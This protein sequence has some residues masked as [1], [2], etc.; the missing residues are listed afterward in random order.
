MPSPSPPDP[1]TGA[2][3]DPDALLSPSVLRGEAD[4]A[5]AYEL[6]FL[7]D[8]ATARRVEAWAA[9][10]LRRDP[11]GAA[12]ADGAYPT[13]TL[14]LDTP[15]LDVLHRAPGLAGRKY[16]VRKYDDGG[17]LY[18]ER[19]ER[20][21]DKVRKRRSA[22]PAAALV[23]AASDAGAAGLASWFFEEAAAGGF[24]PTCT[25]GYRRTAFL[26]VDAA[27]PIRLTLDR[28]VR[29]GPSTAWALVEP[30]TPTHVLAESVI[31][32]LKFRE[33]MPARFKRLV[34]ETALAASGVSKYRRVMEACGAA[35]DG[36]S[37]A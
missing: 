4:G 21:G 36:G 27:G 7:V 10:A 22:L 17:T 6:K 15:A 8:E 29:G 25:V 31:C 20:R 37:H 24:R 30:A 18:V 11:F 19:K 13:T 5:V 2:A 16:R 35:G 12:A 28:T 3:L 14:Y 9:A 23:D 33:A 32:E 1:A 34:E 26:D